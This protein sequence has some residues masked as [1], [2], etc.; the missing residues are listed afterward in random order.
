MTGTGMQ[1]IANGWLA[2]QITHSNL[3]VAL[4]LMAS[5]VPGVLLAPI[6][7][8]YVDRLDRRI[9]AASM[10]LFRA[11]VLF[12]IPLLWWLHRLQPWHLYLMAFFPGVGDYTYNASVLG[13]I[14]EVVPRDQ[15]LLAN[16]TIGRR[17]PH[18][19]LYSI[20]YV[21]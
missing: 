15:L 3:S 11:C 19:R 16:S 10:D 5:T 7:G 8:V 21:M 18:V 13:L 6:V 2:L 12:G 20:R 17:F 1:Y 14:R 9:L 4:V